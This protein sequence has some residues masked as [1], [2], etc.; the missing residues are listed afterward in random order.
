MS[1]AELEEFLKD[2]EERLEV[3]TSPEAEDARA[4]LEQFM[5]VARN[6]EQQLGMSRPD[7][8]NMT[9]SQVRLEL[10]RLQKFATRGSNRRPLSTVREAS[11][12]KPRATP[13][14]PDKRSVPRLPAP[15]GPQ[16]SRSLEIKTCSAAIRSRRPSGRRFTRSAPGARQ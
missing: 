14:P 2:M 8:L 7:V 15:T 10:Q 9:A 5:A 1:P 16:I 6:P 11:R 13:R 4:W 3:L 12:P